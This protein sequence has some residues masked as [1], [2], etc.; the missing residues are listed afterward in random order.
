MVSRNWASGVRSMA[1][2]IRCFRVSNCA[3][4][5]SS[6]AMMSASL[7]GQHALR[8]GEGQRGPG[9]G[10][11]R[12]VALLAQMPAALPFE[13]G[14][15]RPLLRAQ[16]R[17][18]SRVLLQDRQRGGLIDVA[19]H[20]PVLGKHDVE[21]GQEARERRILEHGDVLPG[22]D[23]VPEVGVDR[24]QEGEGDEL[25]L[26]QQVGDRDRVLGVGLERLVMRDLLLPLGVGRQDAHD[27]EAELLEIVRQREAVAAG[28][29][30]AHE[31]VR[32]RD[33]PELLGDEGGGPV[34]LRAGGLER[35]GL[36]V[37]AFAR[38]DD[39][40]MLELPRVH[41]DE[42]PGLHGPLAL[43]LRIH[44]SLGM[45]GATPYP[46]GRVRRIWHA[47]AVQYRSGPWR[48]AKRSPYPV[49]RGRPRR[50][51]AVGARGAEPRAISL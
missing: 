7:I 25:P 4:K 35:E 45:I 36:G 29:L 8:P 43:L 51:K 22:G 15:D 50:R 42:A 38:A 1:A 32:R 10:A 6:R 28:E 21:D 11:Q 9:G 18:G 31:D 19:E 44:G 33:V 41:G 23:E 5:T 46:I 48:R 39:Q 2:I 40:G 37:G 30:D 12:L 34:E 27:G 3:V 14:H 26:D 47:R 49:A 24:V 16:D 13:Q 20:P 17:V